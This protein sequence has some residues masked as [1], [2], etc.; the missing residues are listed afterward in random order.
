MIQVS[1]SLKTYI[2]GNGKLDVKLYSDGKDINFNF[3]SFKYVNG[4]CGDSEF[5][6]GAT[7]GSYIN[8]EGYCDETIGYKELEVRV[9]SDFTDSSNYFTLGYFTVSSNTKKYGK[10]TLTAIDRFTYN[11]AKEYTSSLTYPATISAVINELQTQMGLTITLEDG[12]SGSYE[13]ESAIEGTCKEVVGYI[14]SL[15]FGFAW[16]DTTGNVRINTYKNSTRQ[17]ISIFRDN[18]QFS[19]TLVTID[20]VKC[21]VSEAVEAEEETTPEVSYEVEG[22]Y[23]INFTNKYMTQAIFNANYANLTG[24]SYYSGTVMTWNGVLLEPPDWVEAYDDETTYY[25]PCMNITNT[26]DGA[27]ITDITS[28]AESTS[29]QASSTDGPITQAINSVINNLTATN[30]NITNLTAKSVT[31]DKLEAKDADIGNLIAGAL[32]VNSINGNV[33]SNSSVIARALSQDVIETALGVTV[34]YQAEEPDNAEEGD[35]W[36]VTVEDEDYDPKT[37]VIKEYQNGEWVEMPLSGDSIFMTNSI[38]AQDIAANTITANKIDVD[39]L[40]TNFL[41]VGPADNANIALSP[42]EVTE[43]VVMDEDDEEGHQ[44]LAGDDDAIVGYIDEIGPSSITFNSPVVENGKIK[45]MN[46]NLVITDDRI[47]FKNDGEE[48]AYVGSDGLMVHQ[49]DIAGFKIDEKYGYYYYRRYPSYTPG[50][51]FDMFEV[52]PRIDDDATKSI[53]ATSTETNAQKYATHNDVLLDATNKTLYLLRQIYGPDSERPIRNQSA[54][55]DVNNGIQ[56]LDVDESGSATNYTCELGTGCLRIDVSR[57]GCAYFSPEGIDIRYPNNSQYEYM[58]KGLCVL[59][60]LYDRVFDMF[61]GAKKLVLNYDSEDECYGHVYVVTDYSGTQ[62]HVIGCDNN[63]NI[64]IGLGQRTQSDGNGKLRLYAYAGNNDAIQFQ[65]GVG[66]LWKEEIA[67]SYD[68]NLA[69][70]T[71]YLKMRPY[72]K[73]H[74]CIGTTD[75]YFYRFYSSLSLWTSSDRRVKQNIKPYDERFESLFMD[76][77]PVTYELI[78]NPVVAHGGMVA[79]DVEESMAQNGIKNEEWG[80][81]DYDEANDIYGLA[82]TEC[83]SL[84]THMIQKTIREKEE[85]EVKVATLETEVA[86]LRALVNQLLA[87]EGE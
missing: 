12:L 58:D 6:I 3:S 75:H 66:G 69:S 31:T 65:V 45:D 22:S 32:Q 2:D 43:F 77:Q 24:M 7:F 14:A 40:E 27:F 71:G 1:D 37:D 42:G 86:E 50:S 68:S 82:Y 79:Q 74:G 28:V 73:G 39:D 16:C 23:E 49:G 53:H 4:S 19:D 62:R 47:S 30:A 44:R 8:V 18:P 51:D 20:G 41:R 83:I 64:V 10:Y 26:F 55:I 59:K 60:V 17:T 81:L 46:E 56:L 52:I 54:S 87:K 15:Y 70:A 67:I 61:T 36:Y 29:E 78:D 33:I 63:E 85:L 9:G 5:S 72:T 21:V 13:I 11:G 25:M 35:I 57:S 38:I 84:N 76:L 80:Y 48:K 34:Y